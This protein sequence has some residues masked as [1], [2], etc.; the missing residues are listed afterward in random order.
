MA[1]RKRVNVDRARVYKGRGWSYDK[2]AKNQG[3]TTSAIY[4][5]LNKHKRRDTTPSGA[6]RSVYI[7]QEIWDVVAAHARKYGLSL[8]SV[9]VSI[10]DGELPDVKKLEPLLERPGYLTGP[11]I[12]KAVE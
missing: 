11:Q 8:S 1:E 6:R 12:W 4:Y 2:I 7:P 5:A 9:V 3:V 10:L